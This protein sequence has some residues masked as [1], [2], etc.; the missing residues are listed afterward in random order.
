MFQTAHQISACSEKAEKELYR[1]DHSKIISHISLS[2]SKLNGI[3]FCVAYYS[4]HKKQDVSVC[5]CVCV[6]V[7]KLKIKQDRD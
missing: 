1:V 3:N 7:T 6:C 5:V 2:Y 4:T